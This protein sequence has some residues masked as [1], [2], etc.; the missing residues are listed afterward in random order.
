MG[1]FKGLLDAA[2]LDAAGGARVLDA[3]LLKSPDEL[4][5]ACAAARVPTAPATW[6]RD[7]LAH[8]GGPAVLEAASHSLAA[9][10]AGVRAALAEL[11]AL[12][13]LL[14]RRCPA[15][16]V[17]VDLGELRGYHYHTGVMFAAYTPRAGRAIARGGRYDNIGV[18]FG[19]PRAATGFST[20]L[21]LLAALAPAAPAPT[22]IFAPAGTDPALL[23]AMAG[24]RAAGA[25]VIQGLP[26][27]AG[28]GADMGCA[29]RFELVADTWQ[30]VEAGT[31][32]PVGA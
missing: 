9:A 23:A 19:R 16:D 30:V 1:V 12:I 32:K 21:K 8:N 31:A 18:Q 5:A 2:G 24:A 20:D 27:Q 10:P 15:L 25:V 14:R 26:G 3:L 17:H 28:D 11:G 29:R 13:E 7:L 6:L 22:A 4:D